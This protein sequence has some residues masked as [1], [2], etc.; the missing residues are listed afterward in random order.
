MKFLFTLMQGRIFFGIVQEVLDR[1]DPDLQSKFN[2]KF[3]FSN[4]FIFNCFFNF[5]IFEEHYLKIFSI[6]LVL[7]LSG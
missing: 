3:I 1:E 7:L 5:H 2:G 6:Q 4:G